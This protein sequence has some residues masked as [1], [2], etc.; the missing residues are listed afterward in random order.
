MNI[1]INIES[2]EAFKKIST[3]AISRIKNE[4]EYKKYQIGQ[5]ISQGDIISNKVHII[6]SGEARFIHL[7]KARPTTIYKLEA[8][9]FIGLSSILNVNACETVS[10]STEVF[11]FELTDKLILDLYKEDL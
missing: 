11:C 7:S 1:D 3:S 6:L 2:I 9:S 10:A 5:V 4:A 8:D